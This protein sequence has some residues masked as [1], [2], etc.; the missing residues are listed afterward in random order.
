MSTDL[1]PTRTRLRLLRAIAD[2]DVWRGT[3]G[4]DSDDFGGNVTARTAELNAHGWVVPGY[5]YDDQG[6][7][8]WQLTDAG[9]A[10]L[11]G[12]KETKQ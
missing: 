5:L 11:D 9:R 1:Y 7:R 8:Q 10:V 12:T 4:R 3:D 6:R 2:G